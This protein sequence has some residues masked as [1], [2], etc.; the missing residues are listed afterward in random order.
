VI[1]FVGN[2]SPTNI[3]GWGRRGLE[4]A[5]GKQA[6]HV[7]ARAKAWRAAARTASG[8]GA[9][10]TVSGGVGRARSVGKKCWRR[11]GRAQRE[12]EL[13]RV[14]VYIRRLT[15]EYR[16]VVPVCPG[17]PI[18]VGL[19]TSP[20]NIGHLYSSVTWPNR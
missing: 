13:M 20:T 14:G 12:I 1:T 15:D 10:R 18:F 9:V 19:V 11:G 7:R 8:G 4:A 2:T 5:A 16:W 17:P 3:P 6:P